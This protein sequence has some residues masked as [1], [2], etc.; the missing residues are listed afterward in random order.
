M[1]GQC[2]LD[3]NARRFLIT[4][5]SQHDNIG[6]LTHH[7]TKCRGKGHAYICFHHHLIN[8]RE[9]ILYRVLNRDDFTVG[10]VDGVQAT[11][12]RSGLTR[13]G[14][15]SYQNNSVRHADKLVDFFLIVREKAEF[16]QPKHKRSLI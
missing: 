13:T 2:R 12:E 9:L 16:W 7:G 10:F 8:T 5:L 15:S 11:I 1:S 14:R 4:N 3:G 6:G